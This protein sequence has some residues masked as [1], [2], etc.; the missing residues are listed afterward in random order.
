M[1]RAIPIGCWTVLVAGA[2]WFCGCDQN[3]SSQAALEEDITASLDVLVDG[4]PRPKV[5]QDGVEYVAGRPGHEY[6]VRV[7]VSGR[8]QF[9]AVVL[10]DGINTLTGRM[11]EDRGLISNGELIV[12]GF[13]LDNQYVEAFEFA[14]PGRSLAARLG[15]T[16]R[17]GEIEAIVYL[18]DPA[19]R[20]GKAVLYGHKNM[21]MFDRPAGGGNLGTGTGRRIH[22]P[23]GFGAHFL[24]C[25]GP[26][27][28][29]LRLRYDDHEGLCRRGIEQVCVGY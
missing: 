25:Q 15:D 21:R 10:V 13:R 11:G 7:S 19:C 23:L 16:S 3:S 26:P 18:E 20:D 29:R 8:V 22:S 28:A 9:E 6:Q 27:A 2:A 4:V 5:E 24:H 12:R 17:L 14:E 1:D